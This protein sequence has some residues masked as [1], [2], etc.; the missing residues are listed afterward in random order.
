M[1]DINQT[2]AVNDLAALNETLRRNAK[3]YQSQIAKASA[4]DGIS[5]VFSPGSAGSVGYQ[6]AAVTAGAG[7]LAP[8]VPQSIEQTL[9]S[10]TFSMTDL[11]LW[12]MMPKVQVSN[13]LHEYAVINEHGLDLDPFIQEGGGSSSDFGTSNSS[14][15]RKSVK[16]KY[17]AE[18][19]QVSDVASLVGIIGANPNAIAEE[20]ERGTMSLLRKVESQLFHGNEDTNGLGFD[21]LLKQIQRDLASGLNEDGQRDYN[22]NQTNLAGVALTPEKLQEVLGEL[23]SSPRFGRPDFIMME[24][25]VYSGLIKDSID[26]GRH[27]SMML[28]NYGDRGVQTFGA[29]PNIHVMGPQG[30]VPV[31]SATFMHNQFK[32]PLASSGLSSLQGGPSVAV[33][34][35]AVT[36][37][38]IAKPASLTTTSGFNGSAV[39]YK[40]VGVNQKGYSAPITLASVSPTSAQVVEFTID[41]SKLDNLDGAFD[42]LRIYRSENGGAADT[43]VLVH[44]INISKAIANTYAAGAKKFHDWGSKLVGCGDVMIGQMT[45]DNIE[46]ARLLDFLRKPLASVSAAQQFMLMLFGSPVVKTPKKNYVLRNVLS[47]SL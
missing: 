20:T 46:F 38:A 25:R 5:G 26:K 23:H 31:I 8:L 29:G 41:D 30:P 16:I 24:P 6:D 9:A 17:M 4:P 34:G 10:A 33:G 15:E 32:A 12:Q 47:S 21:G 13:T 3:A 27:D 39:I 40:I 36:A 11:K 35:N 1:F 2:V 28:V 7:A 18:R 22:D 42:Y 44:E 37:A 14:Y 19:R 45:Q 43:C